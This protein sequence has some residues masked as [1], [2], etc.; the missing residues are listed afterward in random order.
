MTTRVFSHRGRTEAG[1]DTVENTVA[2]FRTARSL[3]CDGVELDV[4]CT[5]DGVLVVHHDPEVSGAGPLHLVARHQLPPYVALLG[6]ALDACDGMLVNVEIKA[7]PQRE[8][9]HGPTRT[10]DA[11][12]LT[13]ELTATTLVSLGWTD[14]VIVSSFE[15]T[16]LDAVRRTEPTLA[17]GRLLEW[18][19]DAMAELEVVEDHGWQAIHPFVAQVGPSLVEA[20]HGAG[21]A[22]HAWTVNARGDLE[23]MADLGVDAVITDRPGE[24]LEV[25]RSR[26]R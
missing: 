13:A 16:I 19:V 18:S 24:A 20:A 26:P 14:R 11:D 1:V 8:R 6:E 22:V 3:G 23:A 4:R 12:T 15:P 10:S 5:A 9:S 25:M 2:A 7:A 17:L 21:V